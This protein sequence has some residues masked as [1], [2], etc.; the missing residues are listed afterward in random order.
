MRQ[1]SIYYPMVSAMLVVAYLVAVMADAP[2]FILFVLSIPLILF[3]PGFLLHFFIFSDAWDEGFSWM[4]IV[5]IALSV[6]MTSLQ[7]FAVYAIL[8]HIDLNTSLTIMSLTIILESILILLFGRTTSTS[9][10]DYLRHIWPMD[11]RTKIVYALMVL[12]IIAIIIVATMPR[13]VENFTELYL[14]E[15][16]LDEN[17]L[18][19][20]LAHYIV[21]FGV[22]NHEKQVMDYSL[23]AFTLENASYENGVLKYSSF[24]IVDERTITLQ[25]IPVGPEDQWQS[26]MEYTLRYSVPTDPTSILYVVLIKDP[27]SHPDLF[28]GEA[29]SVG[30]ILALLDTSNDFAY[31]LK[32]HLSPLAEGPV[33]DNI[34]IDQEADE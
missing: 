23:I 9:L 34:S 1:C 17:G 24:E 27:E 7:L 11:A 4:I 19:P 6:V 33:S 29:S 21:S 13:H 8:G 3:I 14:V 22:A 12:S 16:R 15:N 30:S 26:G 2:S 5:S 28:E 31:Y 18:T 20:E 10:R 32:L 25:D